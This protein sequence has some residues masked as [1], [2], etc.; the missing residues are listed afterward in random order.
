MKELF[1]NVFN[2]IN[3]MNVIKIILIV[4]KNVNIE[5]FLRGDYKFILIML[6]LKGVIFY[7]VCV[8]CKIY[9]DNRWDMLFDFI[10]Y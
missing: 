3:S 9:K 8:W 6:G 2:D 5:F 4:G 10:F 7:Y 1:L